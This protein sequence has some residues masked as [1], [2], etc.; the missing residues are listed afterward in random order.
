V[1]YP[2]AIH[3]QPAYRELGEDRDLRTS[4]RLAAEVVSLPIYPELTDAEIEAVS[5]ALAGMRAPN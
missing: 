2:R 1:H 3:Q 5:A 4:E